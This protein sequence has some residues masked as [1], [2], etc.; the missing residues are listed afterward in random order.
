LENLSEVRLCANFEFVQ[1][2]LRETL[3]SG[4]LDS[5]DV[6]VNEAAMPGLPLSWS[7]PNLYLGCNIL[8]T[9]NLCQSIRESKRE[10]H[11]VQA[12][13]SSVYG[14]IVK[15]IQERS[16]QPVSPYGISKLA[17]EHAVA[18]Y[19]TLERKKF[20][21]SI[22]RYFSVYGPRQR[23]DMAFYR[24]FESLLRDRPFT[25][26]GDGSQ[27]RSNTF[28][29]DAAR[30]TADVV[31][32]GPINDCID[33]G[34]VETATLSSVVQMVEYLSGRSLTVNFDASREGDQIETQADLTRA[35][36]LFNYAPSFDLSAGLRQQW[37]WHLAHEN[38]D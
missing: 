23:P 17:A 22:L 9:M 30:L 16:L 12:S 27:S 24:I 18:S 38:S 33:V 2:D 25:L 4:F 34:G 13:T 32:H 15:G 1:H 8:T 21:F 11:L 3:P 37:A 28:V 35:Q 6:V 29:K 20:G 7:Q 31:E 5:Y 26:F 36:R 10:I 14:R 19:A